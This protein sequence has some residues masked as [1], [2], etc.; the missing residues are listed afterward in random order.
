MEFGFLQ[1]GRDM[2]RLQTVQHISTKDR[3]LVKM[4]TRRNEET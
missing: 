1:Y 3:G 2:D 4:H